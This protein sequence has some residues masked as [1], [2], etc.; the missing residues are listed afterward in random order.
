[1]KSAAF[2]LATPVVLR[3]ALTDHSL[4]HTLI[5]LSFLT[6]ETTKFL[7]RGH[8]GTSVVFAFLVFVVFVVK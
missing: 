8:G 4:L 1:V 3:P 7:H 5:L 2:L 6:T